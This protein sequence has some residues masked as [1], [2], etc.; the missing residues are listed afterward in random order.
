VA[1]AEHGLR[2]ARH[3]AV[4]CCRRPLGARAAKAA[5]ATVCGKACAQPRSARGLAARKRMRCS[6]THLS[7]AHPPCALAAAGAEQR[8]LR[9]QH[10]RGVGVAAHNTAVKHDI[11]GVQLALQLLH[12]E[13]LLLDL[14]GVARRRGGG[15]GWGRARESGGRAAAPPRAPRP[16]RR[17]RAAAG[18]ARSSALRRTRRTAYAASSALARPPLRVAA[19]APPWAPPRARTAAPTDATPWWSAIEQASGPQCP[20]AGRGGGQSS[21]TAAG[22]EPGTWSAPQSNNNN[23]RNESVRRGPPPGA[24][25]GARPPAARPLLPLHAARAAP[26]AAAA[27]GHPLAAQQGAAPI[28]RSP[29]CAVQVSSL[30]RGP[31]HGW[32]RGAGGACR[33][34]GG[35]GRCG[36]VMHLVA[37]AGG[38][39]RRRLRMRRAALSWAWC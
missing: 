5:G 17:R 29:V 23:P 25:R 2:R 14:Y 9:R 11:G 26:A 13:L 27:A 12:L 10:A 8:R 31:V 15:A 16:R 28:S 4:A 7:A 33:M 21:E 18:S 19:A 24:V 6:L 35:P 32:G 34:R 3:A 22:G 37:S 1:P 20:R 38:C 36:T 30:Y 39:V